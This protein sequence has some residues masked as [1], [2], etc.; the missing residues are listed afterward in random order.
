[1]PKN[2]L[3]PHVATINKIKPQ[4]AVSDVKL[5]EVTFDDPAVMESFSYHSG[6]C[7]MVSL[8]GVGEALFCLTS[9]PTRKGFIE[10]AVK[11][12]GKV[13]DALHEAEVGQKIGVRGPYGNHFP[14]DMLK[15]KDLIFIGGG[16][17][18]APLRSLINNV[19]DNRAEYGKID[20]IYG[21]RSPG[22]LCFKDELAEDWAKHDENTKVSL[23]VDKGDETW[24]GSVDLIPTF[25]EKLNPSPKGAVAITC[26]PPIMIK[27]T[28]QSLSKLGFTPDQIVTT[29]EMK[30]QCGVGKCGRC[31]V[32]DKYVCIDGPVFTLAQLSQLP[33]EF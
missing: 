2:V 32:G 8:F 19:L 6:Q 31:N 33:P 10:F 23:T 14:L 28:L 12:V 13:S 15:G 27:F 11:R 16:I 20:I 21:A 26:G 18:L 1:M 25:L 17:G 9:S 22:D 5:F 4:T 24:T 30:M 3:V 7:A 29:L